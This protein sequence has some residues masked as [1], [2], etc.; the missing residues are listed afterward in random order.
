VG[1]TSKVVAKP[2]TKKVVAVKPGTKKSG[3]EPSKPSAL[4]LPIGLGL[5]VAAAF[6]FSQAPSQ[7]P[8][9]V[10]KAPAKAAAVSVHWQL[11]G[12]C[13]VAAGQR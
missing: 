12:S 4:S 3:G 10:T 9:A 8:A 2:G 5:A 1:G 7:P 11:H 13:M 6:V